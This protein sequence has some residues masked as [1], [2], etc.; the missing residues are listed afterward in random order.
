M[1]PSEAVLLSR[2]VLK[3]LWHAKRAE[4][5]LLTYKVEG[6]L[7]ERISGEGDIYSEIERVEQVKLERGPILISLDTSGSMHGVPETVAK[8][9]AL[10]AVRVAFAEKR[11]C[12]LYLFSGPGQVV[13][14]DLRLTEDGLATLLEF[15]VQSFGGGTEVAEP[16]KRATEKLNEPEWTNSDLM[17]ITDG[18]F[19]LEEITKVGVDQARQKH[20]LRVHSILVGSRDTESL[21]GISDFVHVFTDWLGICKPIKD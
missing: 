15:L 1:L 3:T 20:G 7:A 9:L 4:R 19:P 6:V 2:P 18:E 8:A 11:R 5:T 13:E 16:L 14:H 10:E 21:Q 12:Y 17:I